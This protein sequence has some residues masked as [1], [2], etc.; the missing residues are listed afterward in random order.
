MGDDSFVIE[1]ECGPN[2]AIT[3]NLIREARPCFS[4]P[5]V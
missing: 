2:E 5:G 4:I 1:G 3:Q